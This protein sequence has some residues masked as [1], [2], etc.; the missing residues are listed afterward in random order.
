M[1]YFVVWELFSWPRKEEGELGKEERTVLRLVPKYT[2]W[3]HVTNSVLNMV[4]FKICNLVC[5]FLVNL[6]NTLQDLEGNSLGLNAEFYSFKLAKFVL[7]LF[8]LTPNRAAVQGM[9]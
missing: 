6:F 2:F 4:V 1:T 3:L 7:P 8:F 9:V 5:Y